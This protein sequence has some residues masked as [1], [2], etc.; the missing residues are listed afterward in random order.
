MPNPTLATIIA[1]AVAK[2]DQVPA[3]PEPV[4]EIVKEQPANTAAAAQS[5]APD[6]GIEDMKRQLAE[7]NQRQK[8]SEEEARQARIRE[9]DAVA[10][11][12]EAERRAREAGGA[13]EHE[14][15][16]AQDAQFTAISSALDGVNRELG[17]LED[18]YAK[19]LE[20]GDFAKTAKM[21]VEIAKLGAKAV[22]LEAGKAQIEDERRQ[23]AAV[24]AAAPKAE[25]QPA[26]KSRDEQEDDYINAQPD[27]ATREWLRTNRSR[28]FSDDAWRNK[29]TNASGHAIHNMG[30][31]AGSPD[32]F[33]FIEEQVG[34]RQKPETPTTP[35]PS[36]E[37]PVATAASP[38]SAAARPQTPAA[39]SPATTRPQAPPAAPPSRSAP[40]DMA[41]GGEPGRIQLTDEEVKF[42]EQN[43]LNPYKYWQ[44]KQQLVKEGRVGPGSR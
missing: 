21:Q 38:L 9:R 29:V 44:Q 16:T 35:A 20:A 22:Q 40:P 18:A 13:V 32:Y 2:A 11:K 15:R 27:S 19:L 8:N 6:A 23:A 41:N 12:Q 43:E 25:A 37:T 24:A 31:R 1:E 28:F 30:L 39:V 4:I 17:T 33:K 10:A 26:A 36:T 7:A 14:R 5:V 3:E 34:L 42:C